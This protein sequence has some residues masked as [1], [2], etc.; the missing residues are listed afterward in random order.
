MRRILL[1]N[2]YL[3][4]PIPFS[5]WGSSDVAYEHQEDLSHKS[6]STL[7]NSSRTPKIG[8]LED[9][10]PEVESTNSFGPPTT[11]DS[12]LNSYFQASTEILNI[13]SI[14]NQSSVNSDG[15][16]TQ[17]KN[18]ISQEIESINSQ[19]KGINDVLDN[20]HVISSLLKKD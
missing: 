20:Q 3:H 14:S 17:R 15:N 1:I 8:P 9:L 18:K 16:E 13:F 11:K 19:L 4:A 2:I 6:A 10:T 7:F 12:S 5:A